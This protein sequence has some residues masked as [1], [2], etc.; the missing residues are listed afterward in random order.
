VLISG[1]A[2]FIGSNLADFMLA[3]NW[4]VISVDNFDEFYSKNLKKK[5]IEISLKN[6]NYKFIE[7]DIRDIS[8]LDKEIN[9]NIDVFIHL[10]AKAGVRYSIKYPIGYKEVNVDGT[11]KALELAVK[12]NTNKFI[13]ASSSSVYGNSSTPFVED[14]TPLNPI[15]PYAQSKTLSEKLGREYAQ[16]KGFEYVALRFFS[17]YGPR[18]RPDLVMNKIA[19]SIFQNE[20]LNVYGNGSAARDYTHVNDIINGIYACITAKFEKPEIINLGNNNPISLSEIISIF[21]EETNKKAKINYIA[22][23][24]E[25]CEITWADTSK[26]KRLLN[27]KPKID[28]KNGIKDFLNWYNSKF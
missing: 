19:K 3:N 27:F 6:P 17:V 20:I 24:K 10:A 12:K 23:I 7:S 5:N 8:Y 22:P 26:A 18:L 2:G 28:I 13:F 21:E 14:T 16:K 1:G 11:Q 4:N 25:E 9:F 15:S